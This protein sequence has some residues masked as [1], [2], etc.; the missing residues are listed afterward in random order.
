MCSPQPLFCSWVCIDSAQMAVQLASALPSGRAKRLSLGPISNSLVCMLCYPK[1]LE[2]SVSEGLPP[3]KPIEHSLTRFPSY[4]ESHPWTAK[5][6]SKIHTAL[7]PSKQTFC[8][9]WKRW[10]QWCVKCDPSQTS[11]VCRSLHEECVWLHK[12]T[13]AEIG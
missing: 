12:K 7:I 10:R 9:Y 6:A 11:Q 13:E 1:A 4:H 5:P 2:K 8:K 3:A